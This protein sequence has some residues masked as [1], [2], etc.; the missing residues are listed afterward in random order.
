L[1]PSERF[2]V[3][4]PLALGAPQGLLLAIA[5]TALLAL[6]LLD[7]ETLLRAS[8]PGYLNYCEKVR[9]RLIPKTW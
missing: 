9:Y 1:A 8:L 4:I 3:G 2:A 6:R 5:L 7:E